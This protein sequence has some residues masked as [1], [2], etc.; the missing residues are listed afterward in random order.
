MT[1]SRPLNV[2]VVG[3]AHVDED[4]NLD[5]FLALGNKIRIEKPDYVII[6]GDFLSLNCLSEWDK[7][8]RKKMENKRYKL[9][10]E[11]GN[12]ALN[13]MGLD[14]SQDCEVIYVEGNHEDRLT[15]YLNQDPT[16]EDTVSIPKD[17]K[18]VERDI[19]WV[20]YKD[21]FTINGVSFTHIPINSAGKAIGNPN[22]AQK[23]LRLFSNSVV[24]GHTHT[25]DTSA[26]HRHGAA[27]LNQA[28]AVGCFFEHVDDY[29]KGSMTNYWRGVVDLVIYD[30]NRFDFSTQ[31]MRQL[32]NE[33][34][35]KRGIP[36]TKLK[37]SRHAVAR[38]E[39]RS[40]PSSR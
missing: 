20:R 38:T 27:H 40:I 6:I 39:R 2:L 35:V 18:L 32:Y 1:S 29:A 25:L 17:L 24:F 21:V 28:L 33:Y 10:I 30:T 7:N 23:A 4:Q 15:R 31:S 36:S 8:K 11:A 5:R 9:E 22:V 37:V 26:E 14:G 12:A 3:D 34:G 19:T 16:F 13:M